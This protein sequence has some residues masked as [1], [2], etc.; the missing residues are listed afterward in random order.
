MDPLQRSSREEDDEESLKEAATG[1][2]TE[3]E[4]QAREVHIRS[5]GLQQLNN[6]LRSL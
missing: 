3:A 1:I 4:E 2:L 6:L 5:L